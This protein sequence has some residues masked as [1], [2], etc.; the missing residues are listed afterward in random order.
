MADPQWFRSYP[1]LG[2]PW[3]LYGASQWQHPAV[4]ALAAVGG[5]WLV[6]VALV[7]ANV[8][9]TVLLAG[10]VPGLLTPGARLAR[11]AWPRGLAVGGLAALIVAAGAGPLAFALTPP[12]P[13]VRTIT[14]GAGAAGNRRQRRRSASMPRKH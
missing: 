6:S 8:G 4:L 12:F 3:D 5:I 11:R 9:I 14:R 1:G 7:M 2:G 13:T 10:L